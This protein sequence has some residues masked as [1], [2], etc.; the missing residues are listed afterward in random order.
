MPRAASRS[1]TWSRSQP[2]LLKAIDRF[3][4]NRGVTFSSYAVPT[5]LGELKR[6]FRDVCWSVYV[7][8]SIQERTLRVERAK[9]HLT[10]CSG[11]TPSVGELAAHLEFDIGE[12][13]Q[14]LEAAGVRHCESIH[15]PRDA[16]QEESGTLAETVRGRD[17][18]FEHVDA[19]I[20]IAAAARRL[21]VSERRVLALRFAGDLT[22][23]RIA[24]LTEVSQMQISR[25]LRRAVGQLRELTHAE[26]PGAAQGQPGPCGRTDQPTR[27]SRWR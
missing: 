13:F 3:D 23:T 25:I 8:R 1:R 6:Y 22:Q 9:Q 5:I 2:G 21:P 24:E 16:R 10:A 19:S 15:A 12:V 14:A 18:Q 4:V 17:E 20:T 11:R 7:P 26:Q 27:L